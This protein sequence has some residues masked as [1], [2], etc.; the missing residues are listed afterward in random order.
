MQLSR[1][2]PVN[3]IKEDERKLTQLGSNI[4]NGMLFNVP[5]S[6]GLLLC[7]EK[8]QPEGIKKQ[9]SVAQNL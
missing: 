2:C 8:K 9:Q 7:R 6:M 4:H 1:K 3:W 5:G